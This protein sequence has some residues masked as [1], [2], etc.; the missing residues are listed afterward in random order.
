MN[1]QQGRKPMRDAAGPR[2]Q[3][4]EQALLD[5][6]VRGAFRG[7]DRLPSEHE[8][9][10]IFD[11]NRHTVRQALAALVDRGVV[12]KRKGGGTYLVSGLID[13]AIGA[14]TRFSA[15]LLLQHRQPGH[16]LVDPEVVAAEQHVALALGLAPGDPVSS[17][18]TIG[19]ADGIPICVGQHYIPFER[20]PGFLEVYREE[21]SMTKAFGRFKVNDYRRALTR[22]MAVLPTDL[23]S[24]MLQQGRHSPVLAIESIDSDLR[25]RPI[26]FHVNRFSGE[27]VQFTL[28]DF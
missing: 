15:N 3:Q 8:L 22:V 20:F 10:A 24:R 14:R 11:V 5:Q 27:R 23:D 19:E 4:V 2:W 9:A 28:G 26:T 6:I 25:G 21:L 13:Y 18:T 17:M 7:R 1:A 12:I 16:K